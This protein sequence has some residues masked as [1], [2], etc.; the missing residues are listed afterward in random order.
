MLQ[1]Y[2]SCEKDVHSCP[3]YQKAHHKVRNSKSHK[4]H[5]RQLEFAPYQTIPEAFER[6]QYPRFNLSYFVLLILRS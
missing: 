1:P 6:T 5:H 3:S 2:S 4:E